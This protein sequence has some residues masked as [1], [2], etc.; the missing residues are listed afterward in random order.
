MSN[1]LSSKLYVDSILTNLPKSRLNL[2]TPVMSLESLPSG[3]VRLITSN[4]SVE[5]F[6]HV[7]LACHSDAALQIL[8]SGNITSD[9]SRILSKFSWNKNEAVLHSDTDVR[10]PCLLSG[11]SR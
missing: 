3:Q 9:E 8:K 4:G 2:S 6:D 11:V 1:D 10:L 5:T 7:I